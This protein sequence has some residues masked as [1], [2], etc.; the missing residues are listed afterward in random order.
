MT[1]QLATT[2]IAASSVHPLSKHLSIGGKVPEHNHN[3]A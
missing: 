2:Q 1:Q 3:Y